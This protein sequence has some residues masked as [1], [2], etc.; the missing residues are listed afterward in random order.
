LI[1]EITDAFMDEASAPPNEAPVK[2]GSIDKGKVAPAQP[3]TLGT[4]GRGPSSASPGR[5]KGV[6]GIKPPS[7]VPVKATTT[8]RST[9]KS[10]VPTA[11]SVSTNP[12]DAALHS[13]V[14]TA[15]EKERLGITSAAGTSPEKNPSKL[16][17]LE[18]DGRVL[19]NGQGIRWWSRVVHHS[20]AKGV[21]MDGAG[22]DGLWYRLKSEDVPNTRALPMDPERAWYEAFDNGAPCDSSDIWIPFPDTAKN[23]QKSPF[24]S[25][26]ASDGQDQVKIQVL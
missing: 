1:G 3:R 23:L 26:A 14:T 13:I 15:R 16:S 8:L 17:N 4:V 19:I 21:Y 5:S 9:L 10:T 11:K 18:M 7:S 2:R 24:F 20:Q 25:C 22:G 12:V 6:S